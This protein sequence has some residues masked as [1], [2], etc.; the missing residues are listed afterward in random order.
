MEQFTGGGLIWLFV[1]AIVLG[2]VHGILPDHGWPVAAMYSLNQERSYLHGF[3]SGFILGFGHLVSSIFVVVAY[4]W[5][6]NYFDL[7]QIPYMS[8]VA[9]VILVI[10]GIREYMRGGHSHDHGEGGHDHGEGGH[11]HGEGGHDHGE[12]GHDHGE[13]G[14]DHGEGGHDHDGHGESDNDGLFSKVKMF[15]PFLGDDTHA[16]DQ[17]LEERADE[18][19]LWGITAF[20]FILGFAHNEEIEMIAICTG[21]LHC[22]ELMFVYAMAVL[23]MC[24]SMTLL[25]VA[26]FERFEDTVKE[27][28]SYLPVIT[29]FVLVVMGFLFI[30]GL[31]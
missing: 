13:G 2:T 22:L 15:I 20:A 3:I 17:S 18:R 21:S 23:I 27:Y 6:L 5:A 1:G 24:V 10:L 16:H 26:G 28:R 12:G 8:Q 19:G 7:T 9:G 4:F 29:A 11:D 30:G 31:I 14:H 25:L